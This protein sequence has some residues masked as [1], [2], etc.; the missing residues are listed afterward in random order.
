MSINDKII[1]LKN[2][3]MGHEAKLNKS[4][5]L[6]KAIETIQS[7]R[8]QRLRLSKENA[9]LNATLAKHGVDT[10]EVLWLKLTVLYLPNMQCNFYMKFCA[11]YIAHIA[12]H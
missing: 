6:K 4:A 8:E 2:L 12:R 9:I 3:V 1:E 5:V 10:K 11:C 7:L